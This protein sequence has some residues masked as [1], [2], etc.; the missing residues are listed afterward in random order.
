[1]TPV[2]GHLSQGHA[3]PGLCLF[4]WA[5]SLQRLVHC[6][7]GL[8]AQVQYPHQGP[9]PRLLSTQQPYKSWG[10]ELRE[11]GQLI[12]YQPVQHWPHVL[13]GTSPGSSPSVNVK[14]GLGHVPCRAQGRGRRHTNKKVFFQ[15]RRPLKSTLHSSSND[16]AAFSAQ[17]SIC[18]DANCGRTMTARGAL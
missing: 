1:L 8:G 10:A 11:C 2:P 17:C 6:V 14:R 13:T 4:V 12:C 9:F 3:L 15:R 16:G 18:Q 5:Q 7:R